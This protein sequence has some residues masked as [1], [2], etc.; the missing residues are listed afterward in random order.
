MIAGLL[1]SAKPGKSCGVIDTGPLIL[2]PRVA[3]RDVFQIRFNRILGFVLCLTPPL[4]RALRD[5]VNE[6]QDYPYPD[7]DIEDGEDLARSRRGE[8]SPYPMVVS[9]TTLKYSESRRY[10]PSIWL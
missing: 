5:C 9:V 10:H 2:D 4:H 7:E 8:R 3:L 1:Q 6:G